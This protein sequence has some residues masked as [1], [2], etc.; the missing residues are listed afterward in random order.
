MSDIATVHYSRVFFYELI[1]KVCVQIV[2]I[3][4]VVLKK[5]FA[6]GNRASNPIISSKY[7]VITVS[8]CLEMDNKILNSRTVEVPNQAVNDATYSG[9]GRFRE[10]RTLR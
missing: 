2:Y 6:C 7:L 10:I 5:H 4:Y 9:Q 1:Q 3:V 8:E